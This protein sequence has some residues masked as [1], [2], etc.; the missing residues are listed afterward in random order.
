MPR[1]PAQEGGGFQKIDPARRIVIPAPLRPLFS[2]GLL[3]L[4]PHSDNGRYPRIYILTETGHARLLDNL[5]R[6]R[7]RSTQPAQ[8]SY[9]DRLYQF[10]E[11]SAEIREMDPMGRV[12]LG[13][14][15]QEKAQIRDWYRISGNKLRP[16][17]TVWAR[18]VF[19]E[20]QSAL[21][22][23]ETPIAGLSTAGVITGLGEISDVLLMQKDEGK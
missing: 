7:D 19:Q 1:L 2:D 18:E 11:M 15:I 12:T 8:R 17:L 13:K 9:F 5:A 14:A 4:L 21:D 22:V 3:Y 20:V 16:I 23:A 6:N 10:A